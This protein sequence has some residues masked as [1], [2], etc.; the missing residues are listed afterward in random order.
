M[1]F[2]PFTGPLEASEMV[3]KRPLDR[4]QVRG[5]DPIVYRTRVRHRFTPQFAHVPG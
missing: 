4:M 2:D 3:F 1:A 5:A